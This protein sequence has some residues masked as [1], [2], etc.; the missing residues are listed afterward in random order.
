MA[1]LASIHDR[2]MTD[3]QAIVAAL[4]LQGAKDSAGNT[5]VGNVGNNVVTQMDMESDVTNLLYPLVLLTNED[6]SEEDEDEA[7]SFEMDAVV[8]PVRVLIADR[9]SSRWQDA[10]P[11][12]RLW[13]WTIA[14]VLL[15]LPTNPEFFPNTPECWDIKVKRMKV[16]DFQQPKYQSV[17]SGLIANCRTVT[18]RWRR[19]VKPL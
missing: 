13:R 17:V 11:T 6:E 19:G 3:L 15:G 14:Q 4:N 16:F 7:G 8:Y 12:Y 1:S 10:A 5:I 9:T 2:C 18:P